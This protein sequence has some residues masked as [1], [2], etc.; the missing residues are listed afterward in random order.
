MLLHKDTLLFIYC[1]VIDN[2]SNE[3]YENIKRRCGKALYLESNDTT[4]KELERSLDCIIGILLKQKKYE[5][6]NFF[7]YY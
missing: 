3:E 2:L 5:R 7:N 4:I 6:I 1:Y